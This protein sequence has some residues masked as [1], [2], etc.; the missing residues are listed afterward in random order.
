MCFDSSF[1][2]SELS[3]TYQ[4]FSKLSENVFIMKH[5]S[6]FFL[7]AKLQN[8]VRFIAKYGIKD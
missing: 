1:L 6:Q 2:T 5:S 4:K 3:K 7:A 8:S